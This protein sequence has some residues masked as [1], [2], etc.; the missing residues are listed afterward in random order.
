MGKILFLCIGNSNIVGDSLGPII[1]SF[2]QSKIEKSKYNFNIEVIGTMENPI[3]YK[4]INNIKEKY[5]SYNYRKI[6]II[7]SALGKEN[8]V[9]KLYITSSKM[10]AGNSVNIGEQI[11]GDVIIKR[12]CW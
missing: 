10:K 1:G 9:G 7:D 4:D 12:N 11:Y 5:L 6:I 3:G 2:L 8:N